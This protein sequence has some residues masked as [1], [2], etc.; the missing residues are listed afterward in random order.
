MADGVTTSGS[1]TSGPQ[2]S[3]VDQKFMRHHSE[4]DPY[5]TRG[6][7]LRG[8]PGPSSGWPGLGSAVLMHVFDRFY[9]RR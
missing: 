4:L 1:L 9:S 8:G 5:T 2:K 3:T 6:V 7:V